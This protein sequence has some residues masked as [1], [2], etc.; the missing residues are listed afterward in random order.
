[1]V[2]ILLIALS[3]IVIQKLETIKLEMRKKNLKKKGLRPAMH[4]D[5]VVVVCPKL[6]NLLCAFHEVSTEV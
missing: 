6:K 2:K 1:M 5:H 3:V 4:E